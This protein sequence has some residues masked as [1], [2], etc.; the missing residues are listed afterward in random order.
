MSR[1]GQAGV[2]AINIMEALEHA[3]SGDG[4]VCSYSIEGGDG[5]VWVEVGRGRQCMHDRVCADAAGQGELV[6]L[7]RLA[8]RF[9]IQFGKAPGYQPSKDVSNDYSSDAAVRLFEGHQ[10]T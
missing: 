8:Y 7:A 9:G 5:V 3:A 1:E 4:V 10:P 2:C 6:G